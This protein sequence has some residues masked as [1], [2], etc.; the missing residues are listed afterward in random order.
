MVMKL[1]LMH[2]E[3]ASYDCVHPEY[4]RVRGMTRVSRIGTWV[5]AHRLL[6]PEDDVID[7][8][9]KVRLSRQTH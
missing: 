3:C 4:I 8:K 1:K 7:K 2:I 6:C 5:G 9:R